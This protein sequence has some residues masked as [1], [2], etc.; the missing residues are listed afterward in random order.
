MRRNPEGGAPPA[1]MGGADNPPDAVHEEEGHAVRRLDREGHPRPG[2][3]QAV[4]FGNAF[5]RRPVAVDDADPVAVDLPH[6]DQ[7]PA[8]DRKGLADEVQVPA[9]ILLPVARAKARR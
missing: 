6:Q 2:G 4:A 8:R 1:R 3:D 5:G 9:D 7:P